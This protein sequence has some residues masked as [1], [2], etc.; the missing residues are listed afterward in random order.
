[1]L[2]RELRET[3]DVVQAH[4]ETVLE[5]EALRD[6]GLQQLLPVAGEMSALGDNADERGVRVEAERIVDRADDRDAVIGLPR[7]FGVEHRDDRVAPIAHDPA[8]SL[9]VVRIVRE[10]FSEDQVLLV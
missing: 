4:M 10:L 2:C 6:A 3:G 8:R 7:T 9:R 5:I 1:M